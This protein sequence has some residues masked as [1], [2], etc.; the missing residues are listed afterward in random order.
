MA[1]P[2]CHHPK[3]SWYSYQICEGIIGVKLLQGLATRT[4]QIRIVEFWERY[5]A[6]GIL[7]I[8]ISNMS[9][10]LPRFQ[11][12]GHR[13]RR[14]TFP[15][16]RKC[17]DHIANLHQYLPFPGSYVSPSIPRQIY[18]IHGL[19]YSIFLN[20]ICSTLNTLWCF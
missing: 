1:A 18:I 13:K 2:P 11:A 8:N 6:S 14:P 16:R 20:L 19:E 4:I 12:T 7:R 9:Y 10:S 15:N 17:D 3:D 5:F